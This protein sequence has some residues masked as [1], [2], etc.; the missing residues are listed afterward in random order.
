MASRI[1]AGERAR[2]NQDFWG[3]VWQGAAGEGL[4]CAGLEWQM[5]EGGGRI[6]EDDKTISVNNP[7]AMQTWQRARRWVGSISPPVSCRMP[8]GMPTTPGARQ[9][10]VL[11]RWASDDSLVTGLTPPRSGRAVMASPAYREASR[12]CQHAGRKRPVGVARVDPRAR[13]DRADPVSPAAGRRACRNS[14]RLQ[15]PARLELYELPAVLKPFA[16]A[17]GSK[18]PGAYAVAVR[19][20]S[21]DNSTRP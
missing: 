13:S 9:H 4:T 8:S 2:G 10:G 6:I 18:H 20:P 19:P 1:Q 14:A 11:A 3:F 15:P 17:P 21:Q 7:D 12:S 16:S 5:S